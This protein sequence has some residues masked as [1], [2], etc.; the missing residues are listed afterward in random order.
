MHVDCVGPWTIT[1]NNGAKFVFSALTCIDP[2]TNLV[3]IILLDGSNPRADYCGGRFEICLLS[4][5]PKPNKCVYDNGNKFLGKGFQDISEKHKIRGR[6]TTV[7]NA[8]SNGICERMHQT[9]LN[10][11]KVHAKTTTINGYNQAK[12]VME[13]AIASC[14][15]ATRIAVNHTM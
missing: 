10:V 12:H 11:L 6:A 4:K 8:Q 1:A 7:K 15:H 3:D 2:V 5:Y 14:I 9:M 13:H